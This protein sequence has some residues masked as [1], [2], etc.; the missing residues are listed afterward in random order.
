VDAAIEA[1]RRS[2]EG[3]GEIRLKDYRVDAISGGT[4][5]LVDVTVS[6]SKDGRVLTS[7][8]ARTDIIMGSVE[9][10]VS[11]MNRLLEEQQ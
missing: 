9:A 4:N 7:R 6:L 2:V 11:G 3:V 10:M 5:A 1:L 8:G